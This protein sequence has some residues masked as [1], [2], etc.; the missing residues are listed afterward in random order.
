MSPWDIRFE[1]EDARHLFR[2]STEQVHISVWSEPNLTEGY[3]VLRRPD[4]SIEL[5]P[6]DH[7]SGL[8]F[9]YW[10]IELSLIEPVEISFAFRSSSG[11]PVYRVPSGVTNAVERLDRWP[12]DPSMVALVETPEWAQ[13]AVIYQIFPDRFAN[14]D[15]ALDPPGTAPWGAAPRARRFQG[16]DLIGIRERLDY[17][18]GLGVDALYLNPIFTSPSTHRYDAVDYYQ[19]DPALGGNEALRHLVHAAH[20]REIRVI[21]DA[22]FNHVHP[23]FFAFRDLATNGPDSPYQSWFQVPRLAIAHS[24]PTRIHTDP[25]VDEAVAPGMGAGGGL[26]H[27]APR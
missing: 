3:L 22:S 14:G 21:L 6:M 15:P 7:L 20:K 11:L 5:H 4:R 24:S 12:L 25:S 19:V 13:G 16:G 1:P 2:S 18:H 27:R 26:A 10:S 17:L 23:G 9:R 8:R